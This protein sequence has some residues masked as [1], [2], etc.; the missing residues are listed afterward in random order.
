MKT[1][2]IHSNDD[3]LIDNKHSEI[4][5]QFADVLYTCNGNHVKYKLLILILYLIYYHL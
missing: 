1:M 4:L 2:V 3:E 5:S